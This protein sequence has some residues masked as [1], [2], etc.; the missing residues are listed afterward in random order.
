MGDFGFYRN[1]MRL[2]AMAEIV[3]TKTLLR[4]IIIQ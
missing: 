4:R 1:S 3:L 2:N